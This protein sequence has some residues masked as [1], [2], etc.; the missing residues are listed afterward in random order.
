MIVAGHAAD[1]LLS[2]V[3]DCL[4]CELLLCCV[5]VWWL[6]MCRWLGSILINVHR[7]ISCQTPSRTLH[8]ATMIQHTYVYVDIRFLVLQ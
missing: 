7:T 6:W 8:D 1:V 3:N 2:V 4:F 5:G